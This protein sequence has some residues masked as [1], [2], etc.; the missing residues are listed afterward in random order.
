MMSDEECFDLLKELVNRA[1]QR[2]TDSQSYQT[3]RK[4]IWKAIREDPSAREFFRA[5]AKGIGTIPRETTEAAT[6]KTL[7][8]IRALKD[9]VQ[10]TNNITE[11]VCPACDGISSDC[12]RCGGS[13]YVLCVGNK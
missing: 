7:L 11:N 1:R 5:V 3:T 4:E 9:V 13:G 8:A 2:G 10:G 6:T 12:G